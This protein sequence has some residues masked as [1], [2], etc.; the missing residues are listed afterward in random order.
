MTKHNRHYSRWAIR[1]QFGSGLSPGSSHTTC[2][3]VAVQGRPG[4]MCHLAPICDSLMLR[5]K[6]RHRPN[7]LATMS[8][9]LRIWHRWTAACTGRGTFYR[10][11]TSGSPQIEVRARGTVLSHRCCRLRRDTIGVNASAAI[12][13]FAP[14]VRRLLARVRPRWLLCCLAHCRSHYARR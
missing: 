2:L 9:W 14:A 4:S 3:L 1:F 12:R 13:S 11:N 8:N 10:I 5:H 6:R 7:D